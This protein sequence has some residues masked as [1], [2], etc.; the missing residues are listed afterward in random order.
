MDQRSGDGRFIGR[1]WIFAINYGLEFPEFRNVRG[2]DRLCF[3]QDHPELPLEEEGQSRGTESSERRP[4]STRKTD[5]L[6]DL[7][8]LSSCWCSRY[9][10]GYP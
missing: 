4:V 8:L 5:R 9:S 6:H 1:I 10:I 2:E 7:R 3:E